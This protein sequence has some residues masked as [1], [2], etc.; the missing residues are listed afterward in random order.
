MPTAE[1][2]HH[3]NVK[4]IRVCGLSHER[5]LTSCIPTCLGRKLRESV[6]VFFDLHL[7]TSQEHLQEY[8]L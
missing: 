8:Y 4:L 7:Q 2:L 3:W 5:V 1:E 6:A